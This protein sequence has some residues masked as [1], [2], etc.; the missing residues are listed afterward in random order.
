LGVAVGEEEGFDV[1]LRR[2][3]RRSLEEN[4]CG[5]SRRRIVGFRV[6]VEFREGVDEAHLFSG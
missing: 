2:K 3:G 6:V 4:Y 5:G 1:H